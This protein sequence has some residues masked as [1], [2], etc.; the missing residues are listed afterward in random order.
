MNC[1]IKKNG[2][3]I[4][5]S[6]SNANQVFSHIFPEQIDQ[7]L[8]CTWRGQPTIHIVIVI[9]NDWELKDLSVHTYLR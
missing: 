5:L 3:N 2:N 4:Y 8:Q 9:D 6:R 7:N 1:Q